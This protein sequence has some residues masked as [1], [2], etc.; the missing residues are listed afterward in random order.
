MHDHTPS[1]TL[2]NDDCTEFFDRIPALPSPQQR[3]TVQRKAAVIEAVRGGWMPI[4]EACCL[5][6]ISVDEF[7]SWERDIDRNGIPGC[8]APGIR[9]TATP[10]YGRAEMSQEPRTEVLR[11]RIELY[12]HCICDGIT[13]A[14]PSEFIQQIAEA[15]DELLILTAE[16]TFRYDTAAHANR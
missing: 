12:L 3:W 1:G 5:Y 7:L 8:G 6:N 2:P 9:F 16:R 13:T 10:V 15:E 11:R 14:E 4:E